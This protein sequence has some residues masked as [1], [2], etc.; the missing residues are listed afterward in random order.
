MGVFCWS[1]LLVD[2]RS[3]PANSVGSGVFR[4]PATGGLTARVAFLKAS[5][6]ARRSCINA[7][8]GVLPSKLHTSLISKRHSRSVFRLALRFCHSLGQISNPAFLIVRRFVFVILSA[9]AAGM[10]PLPNLFLRS[11]ATLALLYG[12]VGLTLNRCHSPC[13]YSEGR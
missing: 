5:L 12:L 9:V 11:A 7:T 10:L 6:P 4:S 8:A 13:L 1:L 2:F 3:V